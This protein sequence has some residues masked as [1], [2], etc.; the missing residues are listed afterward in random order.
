MCVCLDLGGEGETDT[1]DWTEMEKTKEKHR[2]RH[3]ATETRGTGDISLREKT[4]CEESG[5]IEKKK[6]SENDIIGEDLARTRNRGEL[7]AERE[8]LD[9]DGAVLSCRRL[10]RTAGGAGAAG[11]GRG[12]PGAG[13]HRLRI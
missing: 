12:R 8:E 1:S 2:E 6:T 5:K 7:R 13:P 4:E 10:R 3:T 11:P 9:L